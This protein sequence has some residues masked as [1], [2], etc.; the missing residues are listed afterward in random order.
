M[1]KRLIILNSTTYG[2]AIVKLDDSDS[3]QLVGPN[4]IGKS[5][6]IYALN[7]LFII[8]GKKMAFV[9]NKP[10]DKETVHHYFPSSTNS[11]I[12]F[13]IYKQSYYCIL[14][15]RNSE[16]EVEYYRVDREYSDDMFI[17][18]KN[19]QQVVM[20][21]DDLKTQFA[22]DGIEL[23]AFKDKREV[24]NF[25]YQRGNRNNGVIWLEDTVMSDGLSNNFSKVYRY[26]INSKLI[27][28]K[29]LKES[30]MIAD[31]RDNEGINF[32]QKSKKDIHDLL[33]INEEIKTI[34]DIQKDFF[35]FREELN[36]YKAK[37]K[38]LA[39]LV[40]LFNSR[41][42]PTLTELEMQALQKKQELDKT[43]F[44]LNE[45]LIPKKQKLD[46]EIGGNEV[47]LKQISEDQLE[48]QQ[49]IAEIN[50][51]EGVQ[52]LNQQLANFD[53]VRKD[54]EINLTRVE[55]YTVKQIQQKIAD[56]KASI[57][58]LDAQVKGYSNQLIHKITA[59]QKDREVLNFILS[60]DFSSQSSELIS[61]EITKLGSLM[62]LF[63][64]EIKLPKG[65]KGSPIESIED[66]KEKLTEFKK[67][68]EEYEKLLPVAVDFEK[69]QKKL[70]EV[71]E[72]IEEAKMKIAKLKTKPGLDKE[73]TKQNGLF[74]TISEKKEQLE[75]DLK[76][77]N[78]EVTRKSNSITVLTEAKDDLYRR[79][80]EL[81][82]WKE[83]VEKI[84]IVPVKVE[85]KDTL[86]DIYSKL[87]MVGADREQIK[88]NKDRAFDN[89]KY[90]INSTE[91]DE[92]NFIK[93][94][95]DEIACLDE[96]QK[97]IDTILQAIS[98]QFANPAYTLLK[99]YGEFKEY[100]DTKF[101]NKLAQ[102][103]ISDIESL[104][105]VLNETTRVID[106][107]KKISSIQ[108]F[109]PQARLDFDQSENLKTL[110][111]YL[112][113]GKK[114][115][116]EELF[117]I[118]LQLTKGGKEKIVDLKEQVESTGTDIMIRLVIIMSVINRLAIDDK[119]NK[120][121]I[122]IDEIARVDGKNRLELFRFCK[123]HNFIPVCTSTE[124]TILDGFDKYILMFRPQK[125]KKVNLN[126]GYPNVMTHDKTEVN[127]EA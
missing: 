90:R 73:L 84:N 63:D 15:K 70:D 24:F 52:F 42:S 26:L 108:E 36:L 91:S 85:S 2:K 37:T 48:L 16:G 62:K 107:L 109:S 67:E 28:N 34:S 88:S 25:V 93:F 81:K 17:K 30:L 65:L 3:I 35:E 121:T 33:R 118:E 114:I 122:T 55:R 117:D 86:N 112:D 82:V 94:I 51:Y 75:K 46:R 79:I 57:G 58:K 9:D 72:Q 78:A 113:S 20:K 69:A 77:L 29:T 127:E 22:A 43:Q 49:Q 4:N 18:N 106:D 59:N 44:E 66:L 110:N 95:E 115:E 19:G 101:N 96:K 124:E 10:G 21:F 89:L 31:N 71:K 125:G 123:E 100:I 45:K 64:G 6:F 116:F 23:Y 1:L 13:E 99:R 103:K 92:D 56:L 120:V 7:F 97:S 102:I 87:R 11:Y 14:L 98:T 76:T 5:T 38:N 80:A 105:I 40:F 50:S 126:E 53:K 41:Y 74:K 61:K 8:D 111:G 12:V 27:T 47:E 83:E 60:T 68:R 119:N 39:E 104:K 54:T 32:S